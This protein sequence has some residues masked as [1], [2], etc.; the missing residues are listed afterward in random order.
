MISWGAATNPVTLRSPL[1]RTP[2]PLPTGYKGIPFI[3][4]VAGGLPGVC[5]GGVLQLS[6][7]SSLNINHHYFDMIFIRHL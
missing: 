2:K 5:S 6:W 3:I 7:S 1:E 4:G